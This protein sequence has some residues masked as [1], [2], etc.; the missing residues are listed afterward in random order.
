MP[1]EKADF[2]TPQLIAYPDNHTTDT[3]R[4][5][6]SFHPGDFGGPHLEKLVE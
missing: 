6:D 1:L 2:P 4:I 5:L 3:G